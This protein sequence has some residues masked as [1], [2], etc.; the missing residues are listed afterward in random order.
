MAWSGPGSLRNRL[1]VPGT[2]WYPALWSWLSLRTVM[3]LPRSYLPDPKA[4]LT[5]MCD[6]A[7]CRAQTRL[8]EQSLRLE[9]KKTRKREEHR[10][11]RSL[12]SPQRLASDVRLTTPGATSPQ[13]CGPCKWEEAEEMFWKDPPAGSF[14]GHPQSAPGSERG[15]EEVRI[16]E[17][18]RRKCRVFPKRP[19]Q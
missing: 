14:H 16:S 15:R 8:L 12:S 5:G 18:L 9:R 6:M 4:S 13:P 1:R 17:F 2:P 19:G 3:L 10:Q 11:P 7:P